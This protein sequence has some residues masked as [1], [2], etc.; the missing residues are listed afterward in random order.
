MTGAGGTLSTDST[1][2]SPQAPF[3]ALTHIGLH[4][5]RVL[6]L[7]LLHKKHQVIIS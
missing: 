2:V 5:L 4:A 7:L 6:F 3:S 1:D